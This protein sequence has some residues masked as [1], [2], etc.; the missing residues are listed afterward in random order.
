MSL[1]DSKKDKMTVSENVFQNR[2]GRPRIPDHDVAQVASMGL[3]PLHACRRTKVN[4]L[5]V[6]DAYRALNIR[7]RVGRDRYQ[8]LTE[9]WGDSFKRKQL[10]VAIGRQLLVAI[11]RVK[12]KAAARVFA[13]ELCKRKPNVRNGERLVRTWWDAVQTQLVWHIVDKKKLDI[14]TQ[15]RIAKSVLK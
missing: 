12:N 4:A 13:Q 5:Y 15:F 1:R 14:R 7:S 10:L 8:W 3:C 11:G 2:G 6:L 9:Q